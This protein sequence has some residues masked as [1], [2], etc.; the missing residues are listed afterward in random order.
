MKVLLLA[1]PFCEISLSS[2]ID[3]R[4]L[5]AA[6]KHS[7]A[8]FFISLFPRRRYKSWAITFQ[9]ESKSTFHSAA[10]PPPR[11]VGRRTANNEISFNLARRAGGR[12]VTQKSKR[13]REREQRQ[14]HT[15]TFS[16]PAAAFVPRARHHYRKWKRPRRLQQ[17]WPISRWFLCSIVMRCALDAGNIQSSPLCTYVHLRLAE[18]SIAVTSS[19]FTDPAVFIWS[20]IYHSSRQSGKRRRTEWA[21]RRA[22]VTAKTDIFDEIACKVKILPAPPAIF[23]CWKWWSA[24]TQLHFSNTISLI[25]SAKIYFGADYLHVLIICWSKQAG[26]MSDWERIIIILKQGYRPFQC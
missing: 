12:A 17:N 8:D 9:R 22:A 16:Q 23:F 3:F 1:L 6:Q 26:L 13:T 21:C 4:W 18:R 10:A 15:A 7:P 2:L 25:V 19:T 5:S 24:H 11:H 20:P 14:R